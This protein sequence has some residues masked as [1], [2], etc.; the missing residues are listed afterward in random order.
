MFVVGLYV[1]EIA[2]RPSKF[3]QQ[4]DAK[5]SKGLG[6][7]IVGIAIVTFLWAVFK[8][9]CKDDKDRSRRSHSRRSEIEN[10]RSSNVARSALTTQRDVTGRGNRLGTSLPTN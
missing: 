2:Q 9:L 3:P 8:N 10:G 5:T 7:Y 1:L 4:E 6:F